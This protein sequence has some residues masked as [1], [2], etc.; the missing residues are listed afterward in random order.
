MPAKGIKRR[1]WQGLAAEKW[2]ELE[3]LLAFLKLLRLDLLRSGVFCYLII[4]H[5]SNVVISNEEASMDCC[6]WI[7]NV[8]TIC[9]VVNQ[10][11]ILCQKN[12]LDW[13][14][15]SQLPDPNC[16]LISA[17]LT[18]SISKEKIIEKGR[19]NGLFRF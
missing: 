13:I 4:K 19:P 9:K 10:L 16:W 2:V 12:L 11:S 15:N 18:F 8:S 7:L 3:N 1:R 14:Y 17:V 5:A 6:G